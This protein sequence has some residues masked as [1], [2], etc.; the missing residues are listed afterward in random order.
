MNVLVV[1]CGKVGSQ[2]SNILSSMGH[3]TAVID[4]DAASF[5]RLSDDFRGYTVTGVPIDQT[6]LRKGG[7]EACDAVAAVTEDDNMNVMVCQVA[8]EVFHVPRVLA[9]IYDPKRGDVF[10]QFGLP[11]ICP[12]N[13]SVDAIYAMLTGRD[14]IKKVYL[15]SA[16]VSFDAKQPDAKQVGMTLGALCAANDARHMIFGLLHEDGNLTLAYA[17]SQEQVGQHDRL[18]YAKVID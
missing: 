8:R 16:T 5:E 2:L 9:R 11:T 13:L 6:V 1:G 15:D 4:P 14:Q 18:L 17:Q 7:I 3:D 10:S 12:T